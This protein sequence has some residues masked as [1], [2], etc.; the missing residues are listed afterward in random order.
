MH[1]RTT[2]IQA[3]P[4]KIDEAVQQVRTETLPIL[5]QQD[6]FKGFTLLIDRSGGKVVGVSFWE[7]PDAL[8]ASE[9]AVRDSRQRAADAGGASGAPVVE[10]FEV[11]I[12]TMA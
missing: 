7:S 5:E 8:E 12:D 6:G 11:A 2:F 1:A 4:Q 3:D 9:S 10:Q